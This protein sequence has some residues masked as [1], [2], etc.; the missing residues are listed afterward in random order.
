MGDLELGELKNVPVR[1]VWDH[2]AHDFTPWLAENLNRLSDTLGLELE[3]VDTEVAVGPLKADIVCRLPEDG[4]V[5]LI[6]N[7]LEHADLQHLGQ[8]LAY[9]AGLEAKIV[10]WIAKGFD[11]AHLSALCWLNEH[12]P[13]HFSFLAVRVGAV[14]IGD[15][16]PAPVLEVIE[17]PNDWDRIVR[18]TYRS[19]SDLEKLRRDFWTHLAECHPDGPN[20]RPGFASSNAYNRLPEPDVRMCQYVIQRSVGIYLKGRR[21]ES[22]DAMLRRLKSQLGPLREALQD[23]LERDR[24][25]A[26]D[27]GSFRDGAAA[28]FKCLIWLRTDPGDRNNWD[29]IA[30]WLDD[31]RKVYEEVLRDYPSEG[32]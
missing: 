20:P 9:L 8:V 16:L 1:E 10:V 2:E 30:D 5:V 22:D 6:E 3:L 25:G 11:D 18:E 14:R 19:L 26:I 13:E 31:R 23:A 24:L 4:T 12:T 28:D 21:G 15:S 29:Q 27:D 32:E 17:R 7:Q